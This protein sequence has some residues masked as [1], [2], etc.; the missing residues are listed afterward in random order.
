MWAAIAGAVGLLSVVL[1]YWLK[2]K[3]RKSV[4]EEFL[5]KLEKEEE[6]LDRFISNGDWSSAALHSKRSMRDFDALMRLKRNKIFKR[7]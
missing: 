5:E 7:K 2:N 1:G 6:L 4:K 3:R